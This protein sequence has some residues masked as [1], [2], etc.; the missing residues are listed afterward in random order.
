MKAVVLA[1]GEYPTHEIPLRMLQEA[2][3][4]VC[5]DGAANEYIRRGG[6]PTAIVGDG[7]S[8]IP[9][10]RHLLHQIPEQETNDLTKA[11]RFLHE[12]GVDEVVI[13]GAT[14]RREDHSIGNIS[15]LMEYY[16]KGVNALMFTD[17][18]FFK[19][20][21]NRTVFSAKKGQQISVFNFGCTRM[22]SEGLK[23]PLYNLQNWWQ[24]TLNEALGDSFTIDADGYYL[25][26]FAYEP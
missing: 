10:Y 6:T 8:I 3:I 16:K 23:Y 13:L 12:K 4:V 17:S 18:G 21:Q 26:Y 1:N 20:C 5:C 11:V 25:V 24:G 7:D 22:E 19:P 2:E 15:L 9:E 14:G